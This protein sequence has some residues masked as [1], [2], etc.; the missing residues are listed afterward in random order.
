M[1]A[2]LPQ[3]IGLVDFNAPELMQLAL[4]L[5]RRGRL[6]A[7]VRPYVNKQ[8]RWERALA[9]TPGI[10]RM[11]LETFGRRQIAEPK[12][13]AL[14]VEAGVWPDLLAAVVSRSRGLPSPVRLRWREA[15]YARLQR[16]VAQRGARAASGCDA[17]IAYPGFARAAFSRM[18]ESGAGV[19][20]LN[21]PIAHYR[22]HQ[23]VRQ[24]EIEAVPEFA[25][26]W[27]EEDAW[28]SDRAEQIEAEIAAADLILLGSRFA[29]RS[30]VEQGVPARRLA[31]AEYGVDHSLFA[32]SPRGAGGG[33]RSKMSIL[34]VGQIGQRKGL[35]Y[36]LEAYRSFAGPGTE[37]TLVGNF[38]GSEAPLRP[39]RNLFRHM[40]NQPRTELANI[41]RRSD[42]FVFPTLLEG[43][44]LVVL[45]A[46]ACGLPAIVTDCGPG[47]LVRDGV[48]GFIVP[49]RNSEAIVERLQHLASHPELRAEMGHNA[50]RRALEFT[51]N[52]YLGRVEAAL[53]D[54]ARELR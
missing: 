50:R 27:P 26:T 54:R 41:Y 40:P 42:V 19:A 34:F 33:S 23:T 29:E 28:R 14:T 49:A 32:P 11:Y 10:R 44:G 13:R 21:Y 8:R 18:R 35:S 51:W 6:R 52:A 43:M 9:A 1:K 2:S 22:F 12:L 39:F 36:L 5:A 45:E 3:R 20:V 37:L 17:V 4:G 15:L 25:S 53:D 47:D 48:D 24:R 30:F 46:M 31:V 16:A 7:Y 38:A